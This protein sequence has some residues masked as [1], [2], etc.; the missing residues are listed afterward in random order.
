[1]VDHFSYLQT[2]HAPKFRSTNHQVTFSQ[3]SLIRSVG[4]LSH[5]AKIRLIQT[6]TIQTFIIRPQ[7]QQA[8][9]IL[10][11]SRFNLG[12]FELLMN[13]IRD[14]FTNFL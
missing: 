2:I 7:P 14:P 12:Y 8:R 3:K 5:Q 1:L 6:T 10:L 9:E 13:N 11:I 4:Y